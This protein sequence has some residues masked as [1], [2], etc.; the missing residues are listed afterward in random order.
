MGSCSWGAAWLCS[1]KGLNFEHWIS[2]RDWVERPLK[3]WSLQIYQG[4]FC[5]CVN[6]CSFLHC[7]G[8]ISLIY[9]SWRFV[10][11]QTLRDFPGLP[12]Q[13]L[14]I[15]AQESK[16]CKGNLLREHWSWNV[17][18]HQVRIREKESISAGYDTSKNCLSN[19]RLY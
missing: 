14:V 7:F 17:V 13:R 3:C 16:G 15:I 2:P 6:P 18:Q 4:G 8:G 10:S 5:T 19:R 9:A 1:S 11:V 12:Y